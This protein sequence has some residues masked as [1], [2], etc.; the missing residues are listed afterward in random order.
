MPTI[1]KLLSGL[2]P[3]QRAAVEHTE[4]PV[5]T[6]AGAG[7]GKTRVITRRVAYLV[8]S[9]LAAP[10]NILAVTFTNKAAGEMRE[11]VAEL[12][13]RDAAARTLVST[14]HSFCVRVLR[15]EITALGYRSNFTISSES[16]AR[17]LLRRVLDDLGAQ[18]ERFDPGL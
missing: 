5:L 4:G 16:D 7:S 6:L 2:N 1:E 12:I 13:G 14:F 3:P 17:T 15:R 18:H 11:R 10:E 9:G 8:A